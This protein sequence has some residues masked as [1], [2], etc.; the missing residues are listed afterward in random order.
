MNISPVA[1][2]LYAILCAARSAFRRPAAFA[3]VSACAALLAALTAFACAPA[4]AQEDRPPNLVLIFA[5]DLGY[6]D[7]G[8]YGHPTIRTPNLDRMAA[9]GMKFTQFYVGASV[10]T[11]SRA[12]LLT[13]RLPIRSGMV[14]DR[15]RV[16]FPDSRL[17]LP[18][19]EI[20]I[21]EALRGV[22]YATGMVGKWHLGHLKPF[23][24]TNHGFDSY[25]G[26]P[27]SNDMDRV[28]GGEWQE[29]FWDPKSEYWNVPLLRDTEIIERPVDQETITRR[30]TQEAVAFIKDHAAEP[31]FLYL[32]HSMPHTPLFR[33]AAFAG[34]SKAG[35]YGDVIEEIDW[36]VGQIMKT[37]EEEGIAENTLVFFTSDNGPWLIFRTHGGSAGLLRDG[38]GTTYEGGMRVPALAWRPGMIPEGVVNS[39]L[40]TAMDVFP[41]ALGMAG[42]PVP[43]DRVIDGMDIGHILRGSDEEAHDMILYYRGTRIFAARVGPWKA[44]FITQRAYVGDDPAPRD[45][46]ILNHLEH[47][48]AERFDLSAERPEVLEEIMARVAEHR[49]GLNPWPI[50]LD[51]LIEE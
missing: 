1:L 44:H 30:Y 22:G 7:I 26:I 23:L 2:K 16:F 14:S 27:Y 17:G 34:R 6:G 25:Y 24:P 20:T 36:S 3:R 35:L 8:A 31:F 50:Q 42:A 11:P 13:G 9:E 39:A 5:D 29:I 47:D 15:R 18:D 49:A 33:S 28:A 4:A 19:R 10:C 51:A 45:P 21:A 12:A 40:V 43:D 38:K 41:T 37:L 46:P 32:A 48:P